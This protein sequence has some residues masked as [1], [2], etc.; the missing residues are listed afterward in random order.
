MQSLL[1]EWIIG[2]KMTASYVKVSGNDTGIKDVK[3]TLPVQ[4]YSAGKTIYVSNR[5]GKAAVVTVYGIDGVKVAEQMMAAQTTAMEVPAVG[6][7]LVSVRAENEKPVT[8]K[9][10]IR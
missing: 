9:V 2:D 10:T 7:Y 6:F 8:A 4:I 1:E 3:P 5:T